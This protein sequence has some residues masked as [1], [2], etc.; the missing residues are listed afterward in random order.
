LQIWIDFVLFLAWIIVP[1]HVT[2]NR[3]IYLTVSRG[4]KD[5]DVNVTLFKMLFHQCTVAYLLLAI[6]QSI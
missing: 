6:P 1:L 4:T 5:D 2:E 3:K